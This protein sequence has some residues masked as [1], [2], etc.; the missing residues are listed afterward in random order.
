MM[1]TENFKY[2]KYTEMII[3]IIISLFFI[4]SNTKRFLG[5]SDKLKDILMKFYRWL[6]TNLVSPQYC[7]SKDTV[8]YRKK[9]NPVQNINPN[10]LQQ[11][12]YFY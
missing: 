12:N 10:D 2:F 1:A 7:N 6:K 11:C 9:P 3:E 8:L 5:Y 4:Q